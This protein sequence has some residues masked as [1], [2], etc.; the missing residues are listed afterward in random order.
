MPPPMVRTI[1]E[2]IFYEYAMLISRSAHGGLERGFITDRFMKLR[3]GE[4]SISGTIR[5]WEREQ[6][7]PQQCVFC[8]STTDLTTDHLIPKSRGGDDTADNMVLACKQCNSARGDKGVFEWLGQKKKDTLHPLVAGK[9]LNQLRK[10]HEEAGTLYTAKSDIGHLCASC[11]LP[12]VCEHWDTV[13]KLTCF[14]LE[15]V[16]PRR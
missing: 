10:I 11:P 13:G 15:S 9:Y 12:E 1:L 16:L 3:R 6:E 2:E 8:G 14:C 7:V 5:E 4:I